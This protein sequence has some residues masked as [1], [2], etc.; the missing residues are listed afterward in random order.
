MEPDAIEFLI[1]ASVDRNLCL[2]FL[3]FI[4]QE[5]LCPF[6]PKILCSLFTNRVDDGL[7]WPLEETL[8]FAKDNQG[9]YPGFV[10]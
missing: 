8:A 10:A 9:A 3:C 7:Q 2:L 1:E 5:Y 4:V 6:P